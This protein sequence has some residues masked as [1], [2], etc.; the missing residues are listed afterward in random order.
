MSDLEFGLTIYALWFVGMFL[1]GIAINSLKKKEH[2]QPL[3]K[4]AIDHLRMS[5]E[6]AIAGLIVCGMGWFLFKVV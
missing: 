2:R 4:I 1:L 3:S 6:V 5:Y